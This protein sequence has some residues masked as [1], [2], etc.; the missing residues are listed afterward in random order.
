MTELS[1]YLQ[2]A[3]EL[4]RLVKASSII[5]LAQPTL[6]STLIAPVAQF[7]W[8]APHSMQESLSTSSAALSPLAK[9]RC[10]Q[11]IEHMPHWLHFPGS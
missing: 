4:V 6:L 3:R 10:G 5:A 1:H 7:N 8:H 2:Q 11:T 9:T